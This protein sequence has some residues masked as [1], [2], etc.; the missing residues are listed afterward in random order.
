MQQIT[1]AL[2][3]DILPRLENGIG[4]LLPSA[5]DG[6]DTPSPDFSP[7]HPGSPSHSF[8]EMM[9][10]VE[11]HAHIDIAGQLCALQAGD[12]CL[13][14]PHVMHSEVY[15]ARTPSYRSL[16]FAHRAR[17]FSSVLFSYHPLGRGKIV[18]YATVLA[19]PSSEAILRVLQ[20]EMKKNDA[21]AREEICR[22]LLLVLGRLLLHALQEAAQHKHV[23]SGE[24]SQRAL[25]FLE[26]HYAEPLM[27]CDV[28]RATYISPSHLA[29]VFK[30]ETGK[31]VIEAL[32]EIRLHH[33]RRL[34]RER[35]GSVA[36]VARACGFGSTEHFSRVFRRA[37]S[38]PPSCY[39]RTPF[40]NS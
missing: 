18:E 9:W 22:P 24:T 31:T 5:R 4:A 16:W 13:I 6:G 14:P 32:T 1:R 36:Q 7:V 40:V 28:A 19:S 39:A 23:S 8:T 37:E 29:A 34:L 21:R 35:H 20:D 25:R 10:L 38:T 27:L 30:R 33:A 12:F 11:G 26:E 17:R 2:Q 15:D 3:C